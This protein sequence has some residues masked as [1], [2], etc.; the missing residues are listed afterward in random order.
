MGL[1]LRLPRPA[2]LSSG[3]PDTSGPLA[4]NEWWFADLV[5][6]LNLPSPTLYSWMRRGWVEARQ[7]AGRAGRWI[8]WAD[9]GELARLRQLRTATRT[10][11]NRPQA[12]DLTVPKR[13]KDNS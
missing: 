6:H 11:Y 3:T 9:D 13:H 5:R 4:Q 2:T 8:L 10:W 12:A 1:I 7:L